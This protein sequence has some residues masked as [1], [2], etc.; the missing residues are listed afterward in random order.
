MLIVD[1]FSSDSGEASD[2]RRTMNAVFR[3]VGSNRIVVLEVS[4]GM[5]DLGWAQR[6]LEPLRAPC[7]AFVDDV[8]SAPS[9][10][11]TELV[12]A[13]QRT[14]DR[15]ELEQRLFSTARFV[16]L[17][18][19][20]SVA[21]GSRVHVARVG[22]ARVWLCGKN[23]PRSIGREDAW[24]FEP[25]EHVFD[26]PVILTACL[27]PRHRWNVR[28]DGGR[29]FELIDESELAVEASR[30]YREETLDLTD[31]NDV[32]L[33]IVTHPFWTEIAADDVPRAATHLEIAKGVK[34]LVD[35]IERW[36]ALAAVASLRLA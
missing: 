19:E 13:L 10:A 23:A 16:A 28:A 14:L 5:M 27:R 21:G 32:S 18:I 26:R 36:D 33:V 7:Q 22:G 24:P 25:G 20:P 11:A 29:G 6:T 3:S 31:A 17:D 35:P 1:V 34:A 30:A 12:Q 8:A 15:I 2:E 9:A 4:G